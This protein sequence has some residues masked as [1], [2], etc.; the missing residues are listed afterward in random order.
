MAIVRWR[1]WNLLDQA[2]PWDLLSEVA[3]LRRDV[4]RVFARWQS[5][6]ERG[7]LPATDVVTK[8]QDII[9]KMELPGLDPEKDL[10][11]KVEGDMLVVSGRRDEEREVKDEHYQLRERRSGSFYRSF[12]L[13]EGV[14][15]DSISAVYNNGIL[16]LT[17]P[18]A[19][20]ITQA[21]PKRIPVKTGD[22]TKSIEAKAA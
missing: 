5:G 3:D 15:S 11:F 1:R 8:D 16:E 20:R 2:G 6:D 19:A 10:D 17:L 21:E 4:E 22:K 13:P 14:T 7:F 12:P 9:V 18:G